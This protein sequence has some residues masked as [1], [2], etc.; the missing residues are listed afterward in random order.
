LLLGAITTAAYGLVSSFTFLLLARV[1]WGVAWSVIR[2]A[3]LL[4]VGQSGDIQGVGGRTGIYY[5]IS[6]MGALVGLFV[7]GIAHDAI[8]FSS[9]LL[10]FAAASVLAV[11]LGTLSRHGLSV[12]DQTPSKDATIG[13]SMGVMVGGLIVGLVG[14][15]L[16]F[17]TL[18]AVLKERIGHDVSVFGVTLG[19]ASLTG[20]VLAARWVIE[21]L[22]ATGIGRLADRVGRAKMTFWVFVAGSLALGSAAMIHNTV[23]LV[24]AVWGVFLC[25]MA[26]RVLVASEGVERGGGGVM[27]FATGTDVGTATGPLLGWAMQQVSLPIPYIFVLGAV[28]YLIGAAAVPRIFDGSVS[29][30][31]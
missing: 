30:R 24:C 26:L 23:L 28:V 12:V 15:G 5:A 14:T 3:G 19:I 1:G 27:A 2:Q 7:G 31:R 25:G 20:A 13:G 21:A 6:R 29:T 10:V 8:G 9:T 18:G 4:T 22:G 17:S 16:I 11:P